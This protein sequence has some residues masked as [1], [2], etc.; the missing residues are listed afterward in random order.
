MALSPALRGRTQA[1]ET[2]LLRMR[3]MGAR[4]AFRSRATEATDAQFGALRECSGLCPLVKLAGA[5][6]PFQ[7]P[8]RASPD[9]VRSM[10]K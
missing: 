10:S 5:P 7:T 4:L 2:A 6:V 8:S 9:A 1:A 3:A